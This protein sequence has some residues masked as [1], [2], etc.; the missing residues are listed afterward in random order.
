MAAF[1]HIYP[2]A[3][4]AAGSPPCWVSALLD[5]RGSRGRLPGFDEL[6][7]GYDVAVIEDGDF[8]AAARRFAAVGGN[9]IPDELHDV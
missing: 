9:R 4:L 8:K 6:I 5:V 2:G 3:G 1:N 7:V